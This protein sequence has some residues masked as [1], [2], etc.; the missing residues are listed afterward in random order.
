MDDAAAT[1]PK[2]DLLYRVTVVQTSVA[3]FWVRAKDLATA[4]EDAEVLAMD[5]RWDEVETDV[6]V[7]QQ[8]QRDPREPLWSGGPDGRWE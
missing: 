6:D 2:G 5:K 8:D 3:R 7:W 1:A 4:R